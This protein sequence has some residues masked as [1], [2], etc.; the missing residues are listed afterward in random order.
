MLLIEGPEKVL[1][2]IAAVN[3]P[4]PTN[5]GYNNSFS[6]L[7]P[8]INLTYYYFNLTYYSVLYYSIFKIIFSFYSNKLLTFPIIFT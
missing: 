3:I 2:K 4:G 6:T 1:P 5:L 8:D 7:P